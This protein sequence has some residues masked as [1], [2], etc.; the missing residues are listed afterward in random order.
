LIQLK[1]H[2]S[3]RIIKKGDYFT[4]HIDIN[5]GN[6][7]PITLNEVK[8]SQPMGFDP[9]TIEEQEEV[10]VS[11]WKRINGIIKEIFP[12]PKRR[13]NVVETTP[14][15]SESTRLE[16]NN[17]NNLVSDKVPFVIRPT[18]EII[19]GASIIHEVTETIQPKASY[20][21]T[22]YLK[23][24]WSGGLRPRPD[25]YTISCDV[26]YLLENNIYHDKID[27]DVSIFPSLGSMLVGTLVG[28]FLGTLVKELFANP[29][30]M[31]NL[32]TS[33]LAAVIG[34]IIPILF[35]NLILGFI[36]AVVLMRKKDVQPFLTIEDF[37]G[38]ILVGF[39]TSYT[40]S[41]L[42]ENLGNIQLI[43]TP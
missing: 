25:T 22:F 6:E 4:I 33:G 30:L 15:S 37:W 28:S 2:F 3:N 5:N 9:V 12:R 41:Q 42:L 8:I 23:A 14:D 32:E 27:I 29:D 1:S 38:G 34:S 11:K 20:S 39:L 13:S 17:S 21:E 40:S 18:R 19:E 35:S 43:N 26:K 31:K 24:G 10:Q 16:T 7:K 36:I